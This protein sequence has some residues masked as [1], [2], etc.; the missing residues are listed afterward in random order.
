MVKR[1]CLISNVSVR[2]LTLYSTQH[3]AHELLVEQ[4][5]SNTSTHCQHFT[6]WPLT[7]TI[8]IPYGHVHGNSAVKQG[9]QYVPWIYIYFISRWTIKIYKHFPHYQKNLMSWRMPFPAFTV[10]WDYAPTNHSMLKSSTYQFPAFEE[11]CI[12]AVLFEWKK[13]RNTC[14]MEVPLSV[15]SAPNYCVF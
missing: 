9:V 15:T 14:Q 6:L 2:Y 1:H 4:T 12:P 10:Q 8:F 7:A 5:C 13:L 11:S 3:A